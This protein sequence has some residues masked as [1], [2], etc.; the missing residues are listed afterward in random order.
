MPAGVGEVVIGPESALAET[1]ARIL[2]DLG[3]RLVVI[4]ERAVPLEG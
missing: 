4:G 3:E 2:G 1:M